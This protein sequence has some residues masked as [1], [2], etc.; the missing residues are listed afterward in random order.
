M[1][2]SYDKKSGCIYLIELD[3]YFTK[4]EAVSQIQLLSG[5]GFRA[6]KAE[7]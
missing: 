4:E 5:C 2:K 3:G 6:H 7:V 1:A